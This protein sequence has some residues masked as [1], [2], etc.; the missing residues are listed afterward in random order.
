MVSGEHRRNS[1]LHIHGSI[2]PPNYPPIQAASEQSFLCY[3]VGPC[4]L[5]TLNIAVRTGSCKF[6]QCLF[7]S[8]IFVVISLLFRK[9]IEQN[10]FAIQWLGVHTSI[11]VAWVQ[12]LVRG[13]RSHELCS[14][15][16]VEGTSCWV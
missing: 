8:L 14:G 9:V 7:I 13:P 4:W 11:A 2:L 16:G 10:S 6:A 1:A 3:T 12:F 5:S 15:G